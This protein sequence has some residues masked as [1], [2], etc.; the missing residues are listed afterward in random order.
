[1]TE[2]NDRTT[3]GVWIPHQGWLRAKQGEF[4]DYDYAKAKQ[5]AK[6]IGR[7]AKV[8]FIDKSIV[9][10]ERLYLEQESRTLWHTFKNFFKR[11]TKS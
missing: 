4:A 7:G 5:V 11:K 8:L 10:L 2:S 9:D 6:A 1:M 3:Y